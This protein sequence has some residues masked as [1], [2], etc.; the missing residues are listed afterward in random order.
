MKNKLLRITT[1]PVSLKILLKG[2]HRFFSQYFEVVGVS[3][4][5]KELNEV[6]E[7]E[8]IRVVPVEMKRQVS[9]LND[10]ISLMRM[11]LLIKKEKPYIIHTH[12][13]K[14]GMLGMIAGW[15]TRVPVRLHTVAGLPL[16]EST[17]LRRNVLNAVE[18]VT[19]AC[20]TRVYP[21]SQGLKIIIL[22]HQFCSPSKLRVIGNGSSNGIDTN[23]FSPGQVSLETKAD[24]RKKLNID[25][26]DFV[27]V[28]VG[29]LVRDKGVNELVRAF[30]SLNKIYPRVKLLLVGDAEKDLDPLYSETELCI[31]ENQAIITPGFQKDVR[32]YLAI[33]DALVFP[34]YREG[35]P[36]VVMQA[37]AM[38][39]PSIV[40][41]ING[42]NEIII[43]GENGEIIP[44]KDAEALYN[45]MKEWIE[46]PEKAAAM[47]AKARAL[48]E[49]RYEQKMVWEALLEE[50][51]KI[52]MLN[53]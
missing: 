28:F 2:Q 13:P 44:P 4:P 38:C 42:C 52:G 25:N 17:G 26:S 47:A 41:D 37:G 36:N 49:S 5:G 10:L 33:A 21:N 43:S 6:A 23:W 31:R 14:A 24:L 50:Y 32:P 30:S 8:G 35:F 9:L 11:Y 7:S 16:M 18:K 19:Y 34:S 12:T 1:V 22:Q 29:R 3:S 46:Q 27:F 39:L 48:V 20:A 45:K 15:L 51:R 40:T 53:S